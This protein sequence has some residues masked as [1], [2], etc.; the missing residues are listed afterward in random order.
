MKPDLERSLGRARNLTSETYRVDGTGIRVNYLIVPPQSTEFPSSA[1]QN[2]LE[3]IIIFLP[4]WMVNADSKS[5]QGIS[6]SFANVG[7]KNV[8]IVD[9]KP[10]RVV[11][12]SLFKEAQAIAETVRAKGTKRITIVG[13]SEGGIRATNLAAILQNQVDN[14]DI[15]IDGVV[16]MDSMGLYKQKPSKLFTGFFIN[17]AQGAS[18]IRRSPEGSE[19]ESLIQGLHSGTDFLFVFYRE[20][21]KRHVHYPRRLLSQIREMA[22]LNTH[23]AQLRV[24]VVLIQGSDDPVSNPEKILPGYRNQELADIGNSLRTNVLPLCPYVTMGIIENSSHLSPFFNPD[25][26]ATTSLSLLG[27]YQR[28][29]ATAQ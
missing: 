1:E 23:L 25:Q 3:D 21:L 15:V 26:T 22:S 13:Y 5:V 9:T 10:E 16:L 6:Q 14:P 27:E 20:L 24:P 7:G 17:A 4:G 28:G 8:F 12:D 19:Y 29:E 18:R 11:E 2:P